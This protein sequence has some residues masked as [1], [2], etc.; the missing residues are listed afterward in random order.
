ML[1]AESHG[2]LC[3]ILCARGSCDLGTWRGH[4]IGD[5]ALSSVAI[6]DI[7]AL[8]GEMYRATTEQINDA[9]TEFYM[10]LPDEEDRFSARVN[11]LAEWCQ[12][13]VLGLAEGGVSEQTKLPENSDEIMK[14]IIKI[15][16]AFAEDTLE[17]DE[18]DEV[19]YMELVEYVRTGVLLINEE[20]Q[21]LK[22]NRTLQ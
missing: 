20:M 9:L 6:Q 1:G 22:V 14:D 3:G 10:L 18:D 5:E 2:L 12:G 8:L 7:D 4:V 13:F 11:G 19:D 21:P 17:A 16:R 15:S